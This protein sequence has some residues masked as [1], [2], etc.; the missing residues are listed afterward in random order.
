MKVKLN[1]A[2][3]QNILVIKLLTFLMFMMFAMTTDA[4][5]LII[6]EVVKQ[7]KLSLTAAGAFQYASMVAIALGGFFL[8]FI[9]D[10]LGRKKTIIIGLCLFAINSYLY[11]V[12]NSFAFFLTLMVIAGIAIGIFKTGALALIG[13]ISKSTTEHTSTMNT[14]EGFFAVGAIIGTFIVPY[15]LSK[16]VKWHWLY[17]VAGTL[18][19]ILIIIALLVKYPQTIRKTEEPINF[20]GTLSMM[21]DPYAISFS[22]GAFLYVSVECAIYV[23]M[24]TLISGYKGNAFFI[25]TYSLSIFFI[26]RAAG[27][28]LGSW[29]MAK[30]NWALVLSIFTFL[31]LV[32]FVGSV[33]GGIS[34]AIILLPISGLFMSVVYPTLNSKG[35]SCFPKTKHGSVAGIILFFTASGAA[36]GPLAMGAVSDAFG[37]IKYGFVLATIFA[38]LLFLAA[39]LNFVFNPTKL[40]LQKLDQ[41][42]Y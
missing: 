15:F 10:K 1:S 7:F 25:A 31:I 16:G 4:V 41:S 20:K 2:E 42:E 11:I 36:L 12:G 39:I 21:K 32:C 17:V 24:P 22:I 9:A 8:G 5:G 27:R 3:H 19:V 37:H 18:C 30:F 33:V 28:F 38:G 23:W 13:D 34:F 6:P 29:V 14:V 35:I 26:L 40:R